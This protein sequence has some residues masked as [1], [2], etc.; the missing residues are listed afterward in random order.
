LSV[1]ENPEVQTAWIQ[2]E[3]PV[4]FSWHPPKDDQVPRYELL[5]NEARGLAVLINVHVPGSPEKAEAIRKLEECVMW[6]NA[7]IAR[8]S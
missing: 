1:I 2:K 6:A 7:G 8:R 3:I 4:R 5:R